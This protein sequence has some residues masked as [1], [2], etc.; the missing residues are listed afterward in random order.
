MISF[1]KIMFSAK[2]EYQSKHSNVISK[3]NFQSK[4]A[5]KNFSF[6]SGDRRISTKKITTQP[7]YL[8]AR[9]I[10]IEI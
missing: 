3:K 9:V 10:E 1:P 2:E 8:E 5:K 7:D 4:I 6:F